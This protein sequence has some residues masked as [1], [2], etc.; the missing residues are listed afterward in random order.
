MKD[1]EDF[2]EI[3]IVADLKISDSS[4]IDTV[5]CSRSVRGGGVRLIIGF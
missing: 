4:R 2:G 3:L 1:K 5:V